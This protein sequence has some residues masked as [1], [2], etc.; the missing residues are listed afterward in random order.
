VTSSAAPSTHPRDR[1]TS[2]WLRW[3]E[4]VSLGAATAVLAAS[5]LP[6]GRSGAADRSSYDLVAAAVDLAVL[7]PAV[8]QAARAWYLLPA[9][10]GAAWLAGALDRPLASTALAAL[11]GAS[12]VALAV[13]TVRSPL[14]EQPATTFTAIA[15][16]IAISAALAGWLGARSSDHDRSR[17]VL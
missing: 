6:W 7:G 12:G 16:A 5:F 9:L 15:G 2:R 1:Q 8:A 4:R 11:I 3:A 14:V 17:S 13:A 10:V